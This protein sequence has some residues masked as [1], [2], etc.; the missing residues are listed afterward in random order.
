MSE[1]ALLAELEAMLS[2][3]NYDPVAAIVA[4]ERKRGFHVVRPGDKPW[5]CHL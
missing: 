2:D 3:P 1:A 5:F 4:G